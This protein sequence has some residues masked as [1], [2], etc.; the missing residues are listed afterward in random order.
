[1]FRGSLPVA[2]QE[3]PVNPD[4]HNRKECWLVDRTNCK[5]L[6][7]GNRVGGMN[8]SILTIL[9]LVLCGFSALAQEHPASAANQPIE[10]LP[11][12]GDLHHPIATSSPEAQRFFD[13]STEGAWVEVQFDQA[14]A[15][16]DVQ[17]NLQYF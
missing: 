17:P 10:L 3:P 6:R 4:L 13:Q 7:D 1:M 11:G 14:W 2:K 8:K 15:H 5:M 12:M 9:T 16:A